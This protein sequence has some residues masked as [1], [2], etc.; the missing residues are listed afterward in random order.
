MKPWGI[1]F[2]LIFI[3]SIGLVCAEKKICIDFDEPGNIE[4]LKYEIHNE[5][6]SFSW[7]QSNDE[8]NCS[9]IDYYSIYVNDSFLKNT[10]SNSFEINKTDHFYIEIYAVDFAG[11][12]G[13]TSY[14]NIT[15]QEPTPTGSSSGGSSGSGASSD[16]ETNCSSWSEC[17]D[18]L[19]FRT[20]SYGPYTSNESRNCFASNLSTTSD[21]IDDNEND[22]YNES[23]DVPKEESGFSLITGQAISGFLETARKPKISVPIIIG[24]LALTL[25]VIRKKLKRRIN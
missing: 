10:S 2:I 19:Q 5:T 22:S 23:L 11:N 6:I 16:Y 1:F 3:L 13:N 12:R 14:L 7:N 4:N 9:G 20:C 25:F 18:N 17:A 8:P 21:F 15:I 24:F